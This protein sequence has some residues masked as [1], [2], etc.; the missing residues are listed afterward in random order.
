MQFRSNT[1][2]MDRGPGLALAMRIATGFNKLA[3]VGATFWGRSRMS[4]T[5][6]AE[7]SSKAFSLPFVKASCI[8]RA[9]KAT[10]QYQSMLLPRPHCPDRMSSGT[11][12][13]SLL[14]GCPPPE[15]N[16]LL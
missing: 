5:S 14:P 15:T 3:W 6:H 8:T 13:S 11:S 2:N 10:A 12:R 16:L 9:S 7:S 4:N 1:K